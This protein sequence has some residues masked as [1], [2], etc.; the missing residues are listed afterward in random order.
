MGRTITRGMCSPATTRKGVVVNVVEVHDTAV[1][2]PRPW[3]LRARSRALAMTLRVASL[4]K[5]VPQSSS[6][7]A[8]RALSFA[9][10][11]SSLEQG[12]LSSRSILFWKAVSRQPYLTTLSQAM[13]R[14]ESG[15]GSIRAHRGTERRTPRYH[16]DSTR[17][18]TVWAGGCEGSP[19][20][21]GPRASSGVSGATSKT[22]CP[23]GS[24]P[25]I[26]RQLSLDPKPWRKLPRF[27][28]TQTTDPPRCSIFVQCSTARA[29]TSR[30]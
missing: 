19:G 5:T 11:E 7:G 9:L 8:L 13:S 22:Q 27:H 26:T 29:S 10:I 4:G 21:V 20:E 28:R 14:M 6:L 15:R 16:N 1:L 30:G 25:S 3:R 24:Y 2:G 18:T 12:P 23:Q 17:P